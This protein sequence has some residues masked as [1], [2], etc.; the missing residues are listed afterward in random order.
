MVVLLSFVTMAQEDCEAADSADVT[1][2][3]ENTPAPPTR[4]EPTPTPSPEPVA[5]FRLLREIPC[6]DM[7]LQVNAGYHRGVERDPMRDGIFETAMTI[8]RTWGSPSYGE[9]LSRVMECEEG[10]PG[11]EYMLAYPCDE[12]MVD[13]WLIKA[14]ALAAGGNIREL[15]SRARVVAF[16][17]LATD[18]Y[19]EE[20]GLRVYTR[21][22]K[23]RVEQCE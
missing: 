5:T 7:I 13:Y 10:T 9:I 4:L 6:D 18:V 15:E 23:A 12:M 17:T 14:A 21:D 8:G 11:R 3:I 20:A 22:V 2:A 16:G 1:Q 19:S